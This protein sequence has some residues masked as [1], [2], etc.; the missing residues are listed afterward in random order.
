[1]NKISPFNIE[2]ELWKRYKY[3][4]GIDEAGRG[5]IAGPVSVGVAILPI[6]LSD[7]QIETEFHDVRDSKAFSSE[8]SRER[9]YNN[10]RQNLFYYDCQLSDSELIDKVGIN[11]AISIATLQ[12]L[13]RAINYIGND[14][15][16]ILVDMGLKTLELEKLSDVYEY[17]KGDK[18]SVSISAASII[19][20]V[21]RDNMMKEYD[22][23]YP[24][25]N[26]KGNKGYFGNPEHI[27]AL[28]ECKIIPPIYRRSFSTVRELCIENLQ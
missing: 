2:R 24:G 19:A 7:K 10:L 20:K 9:V 12:G 25:F 8:K 3:I 18:L 5:A 13:R 22:K 17:I 4:I 21:T 14:S 27:N 16:C 15:V 1:M 11:E 26:L 23:E 28:K 6:N